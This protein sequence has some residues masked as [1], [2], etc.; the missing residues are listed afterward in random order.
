MAVE[1]VI[2]IK[3][4]LQRGLDRGKYDLS[5]IESIMISRI[6]P[7]DLAYLWERANKCQAASRVSA[8]LNRVKNL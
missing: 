3:A 4:I 7:L 2:V 8:V 1:D 6:V 5:D